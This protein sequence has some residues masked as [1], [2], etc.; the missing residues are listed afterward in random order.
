MSHS[1]SGNRVEAKMDFAARQSSS[2]VE[3]DEREDGADL[4][5]ELAVKTGQRTV[6]NVFIKGHHVG[7]NNNTQ[8]AAASGKLQELLE[9]PVAG[10]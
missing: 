10:A 2:T 9:G 4:Q 5:L 7:G 1:N 6:P 8:K 3:L